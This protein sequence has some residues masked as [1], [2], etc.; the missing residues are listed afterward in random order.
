MKS[1]EQKAPHF[2]A[3]CWGRRGITIMVEGF[4]ADNV[5]GVTLLSLSPE[6]GVEI[7]VPAVLAL[8]R[9]DA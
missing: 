8:R 4:D 2:I 6:V 1:H 9:P 5:D 7:G 3:W